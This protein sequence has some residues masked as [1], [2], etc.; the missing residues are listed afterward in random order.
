M[1]LTKITESV[2]QRFSKWLNVNSTTGVVTSVV[3]DL[4]GS[5][6]T[7]YPSFACRAWVNFDGRAGTTSANI[8]SLAYSQSGFIITVTLPNHGHLVNHFVRLTFQS[9]AASAENFT[10]TSIV[11]IN[12]FTVTSGTSRTTSG[13]CTCIR[14]AIR[15]SGNIHSVAYLSTGD[16]GFNMN[17]M[18]DVNYCIFSTAHQDSADNTGLSISVIS[19][20]T[21]GYRIRYNHYEGGTF[22]LRD[23]DYVGSGVFR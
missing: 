9:G 20:T 22:N 13:T 2:V 10:V 21:T 17:S 14:S 15:G 4:I 1:G 12:T 16:Y 8:S 6:T 3:P 11:D 19:R 7:L 18:P 5:N 23:C